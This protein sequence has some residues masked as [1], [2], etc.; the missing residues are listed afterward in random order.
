MLPHATPLNAAV[1]PP[2]WCGAALQPR[3]WAGDKTSH[4]GQQGQLR[5]HQPGQVRPYWLLLYGGCHQTSSTHLPILSLFVFFTSCAMCSIR[6][7]VARGKEG[8]IDFVRGSELKVAKGKRG[9]LLVVSQRMFWC[10]VWSLQ[11]GRFFF[12]FSF[13]IKNTSASWLCSMCSI[14]F[15]SADCPSDQQHMKK[16][17]TATRQ[18]II[19]WAKLEDCHSEVT[20]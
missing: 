3:D 1:P 2:G 5:Q 15:H 17:K 9:H 4:D 11:G 20:C 10:H 12:F 8:I 14:W 16:Q 19:L 13:N 7:A 6:F 18:T